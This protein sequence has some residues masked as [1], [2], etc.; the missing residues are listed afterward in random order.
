MYNLH[1]DQAGFPSIDESIKIEK[2]LH[3]ELQ[4]QGNPVP[5]PQWFREGKTATLTRFSM[6][7]NFP[8]YLQT[9]APKNS[10]LHELQ[11]RQNYKP[12]GRLPYSSEMTRLALLLRYTSLQSYKILLK[13]FPL[14]SVSLQAKLKSSSVD[15]VTAAKLLR[16]KNAISEDVVLMADEMYLQKK[17][18]YGGGDYV[19][20]DEDGNL[21]KGIMVFMIC[22]LKKTIPI[23]VKA[24]PETKLNGTWIA[25]K[26]EECVATLAAKGFRVRAIVTDNHSANVAA[27]NLLL[28][29]F[30]REG[31]Y[32]K[33]PNNS[34][35]TYLF[36]DNVHLLKNVRNYLLNCHKFVFPSFSFQI[37][38]QVVASSEN[39][40]V[41]WIDLQTV[42]KEDAKLMAN[43][44][45][46]PKL[47]FEALHP[48]HNKQNV[49]LAAAIFHETTIAG[50][51]AYL[52][53][54][55]DMAS[56]I[57]LINTWWTIVNSKQRFHP[58]ALGNAMS[59][60]MEKLNL[61]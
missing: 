23:V 43:L 48:E 2:D 15:A 12:Q 60:V 44:R 55:A 18:Q 59:R 1:F 52:P 19:G 30:P 11:S 51:R 26:L 54:R 29:K 45:K 34:T 21:Y 61:C 41:S 47:S 16:K 56:F 24:S 57:S 46:A 50:C 10:I 6:L 40:Y 31:V 35:N 14:P 25:E 58:N 3:V 9:S 36:F 5:L 38:D 28:K 7:Q 42:H 13:H 17:A 20:A 37:K 8:S 49:S 4:Y 53:D 39:G 32:F 33:H 27:F 22:G